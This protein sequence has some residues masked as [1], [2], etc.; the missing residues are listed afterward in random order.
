[1][2]VLQEA[3]FGWQG[4]GNPEGVICF[5]KTVPKPI[6]ELLLKAV[7]QHFGNRRPKA[8]MG[9]NPNPAMAGSYHL[10]LAEGDFFMRV[11]SRKGYPGLETELI[12]F[13]VQQ[14]VKAN[15]VLFSTPFQDIQGKEFRL[16][17]RPFVQG[18]HF[19]GKEEQLSAVSLELSRLHSCLARFPQ[20][21]AIREKAAVRY[22][23]LSVVS[24][25]LRAFLRVGNLSMFMEAEQWALKNRRWLEKMADQYS[26]DFD[27]AADA[28]PIHGEV[29][30][31]NVIFSGGEAVFI[32]FEESVHSFASPSWDQAY[33][34]QRFCLKDCPDQRVLASRCRIIGKYLSFEP[35][36]VGRMI[37]QAAWMSMATLLDLRIRQ[38]VLSPKAEYE[39]FV[40]L[41]EQ[42]LLLDRQ[43]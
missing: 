28:Q 6:E 34:I 20:K 38:G 42:A 11:T 27:L 30:T 22:N 8:L 32:D 16:D 1:M 41:E 15:P 9:L 36:Q 18:D 19:I 31:G 17:I 33:L 26:F 7:Y 24:N 39:K 29:H 5:D 35:A 37:R 43:V 10:R 4:G 12:D 21:E 2:A 23:R 14:G 40:R 25:E 13:L 3:E